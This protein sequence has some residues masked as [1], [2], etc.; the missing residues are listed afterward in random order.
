M[1]ELQFSEEEQKTLRRLGVEAV[2]LF[3]SHAQGIEG[4]LSDVD[5]G[6]LVALDVQHVPARR[7]VL[8]DTIYDLLSAKI[9]KLVDIDIVF[10]CE[11][12]M[13]LQSHVARYGVVLYEAA[14]HIFS[15]FRERVMERYADFAP[16]RE[17]FHKAI[18]ARIPL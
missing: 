11:A 18:L 2:I 16:L 7:R 6:L 17:I 3:G 8:Y 10:L 14:P 15:R 5:V 4:P 9:Q 1:R 12:P 13:E